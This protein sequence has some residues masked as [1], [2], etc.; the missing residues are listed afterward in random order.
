M[1]AGG[2]GYGGGA[3]NDVG[4]TFVLTSD[5]VTGNTA[6]TFCAALYNQGTARRYFVTVSGS[7][8][9]WPGSF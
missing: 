5:T 2:N 8:V 1:A 9:N 6:V 4:G 3:F 7:V